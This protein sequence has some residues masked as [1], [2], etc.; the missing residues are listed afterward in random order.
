MRSTTSS[1]TLPWLPARPGPCRIPSLPPTVPASP[2]RFMRTCGRCSAPTCRSRIGCGSIRSRRYSRRIDNRI[3]SPDGAK[4]NPGLRITRRC[5]PLHPGY[6]SRA[7]PQ[8]GQH[9]EPRVTVGGLEPR[10]AL[11]RAHRHHRVPADPAVAAAGV[12]AERGQ[13]PLNLLQFLERGRALATGK[14][15]HELLFVA[16]AVGVMCRREGV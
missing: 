9:L 16:V 15:L 14:F 8:P 12:E 13:T 6:I 3:R 1:R 5:A 4:R 7:L 11:E 10:L 2:T